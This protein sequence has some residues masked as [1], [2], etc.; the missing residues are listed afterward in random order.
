[1]TRRAAR[2]IGVGAGGFLVQL[3]AVEALVRFGSLSPVLATAV[4][5]EAAIL[6]NFLWHERWTWADRPAGDRRLERFLRFNGVTALVSIGG[7]V[8][9]IQLL[10]GRWHLP[11]LLANASAVALMSAVNYACADRLVFTAGR[12]RAPLLRF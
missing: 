11:L 1:M 5:V 10:T 2:F 8:A 12:P 6:H 7:N 9:L 3:G 4:A